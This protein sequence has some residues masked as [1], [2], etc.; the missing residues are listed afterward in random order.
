MTGRENLLQHSHLPN[1]GSCNIIT[2]IT[3]IMNVTRWKIECLVILSGL[4]SHFC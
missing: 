3:Y 1:R 4:V 2:I